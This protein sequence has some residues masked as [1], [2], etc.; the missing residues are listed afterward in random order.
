MTSDQTPF[1]LREAV[2]LVLAKG[3]LHDPRTVAAEVLDRM[4]PEDWREAIVQALPGFV[5]GVMSQERS[6]ALT[7]LA[8]LGA[9]NVPRRS[10][11]D[12]RRPQAYVQ[13]WRVTGLQA[14]GR[15][16]AQSV[17][18]AHG[19][20]ALGRCSPGDLD[21]IAQHHVQQAQRIINAGARYARLAQALRDAD[22]AVLADLG[23]QAFLGIWEAP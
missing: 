7:A 4:G 22:L 12:E 13:G 6:A 20:I 21:F 11:R 3:E 10:P 1:D 17:Y 8:V 9:V 16:M 18:T 14:Y 19:W 15:A 5:R 2:R 23:P